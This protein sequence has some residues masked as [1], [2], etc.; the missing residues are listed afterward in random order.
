[1]NDPFEEEGP[2]ASL[3]ARHPELAAIGEALTALRKGHPVTATCPHCGQILSVQRIDSTGE[4]WILC[5][6]GCTRFHST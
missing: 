2:P 1:M 4:C 6:D 3:L 5:P